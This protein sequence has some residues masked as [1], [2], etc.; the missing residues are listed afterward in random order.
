MWVFSLFL[1]VPLLIGV[2]SASKRVYEF[3]IS[4]GVSRNNALT[5][6]VVGLLMLVGVMSSPLFLGALPL[7]ALAG[8][9]YLYFLFVGGRTIVN[10]FTGGGSS[11]KSEAAPPEHRHSDGED[12]GC[13]HGDGHKHGDSQGKTDAAP[14]IEPTEPKPSR[15]AAPPAR[16]QRTAAELRAEIERRIAEGEGQGEKKD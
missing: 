12:C 8:V 6:S 5:A 9:S 11:S 16:P 1:V 14:E 13:D 7:R 15:P 3:L 10:F 2:A 4:R